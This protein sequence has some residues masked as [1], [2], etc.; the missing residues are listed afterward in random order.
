[1]PN[2]TNPVV[3]N[4]N[5]IEEIESFVEHGIDIVDYNTVCYDKNSSRLKRSLSLNIYKY[6]KVL[7][8]ENPNEFFIA[9][10]D[11]SEEGFEV[12]KGKLPGLIDAPNERMY[13]REKQYPRTNYCI[14]GLFLFFF[15]TCLSALGFIVFNV[16]E[17]TE[18]GIMKSDI[19][20]Y[21]I[22]ISKMK[23]YKNHLLICNF[24]EFI[25]SETIR[26]KLCRS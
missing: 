21:I 8:S 6:Q 19:S 3:K 17:N 5:E 23:K 15:L 10:E 7:D 24:Q 12:Q 9:K 18:R 22:Y 20:T 11:L 1:M 16:F 14:H 2:F 26:R 4:N 13:Q 25:L